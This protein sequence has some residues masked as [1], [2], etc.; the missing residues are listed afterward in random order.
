MKT[1]AYWAKRMEQLNEAQLAKGERYA[2]EMEAEY[3][4]ALARIKRDTEAW[5]A[6][7]AKNNDVSLAE[8]RK[9][10]SANE[11]QEFKWTV[12]DYIKAGRENAVDQ[13][14]MKQLENASAKVHISKLEALQTQIQQEV[15]L[16]AA[17][18][19]K[20]AADTLGGIYKDNY[21]K[22][23]FEL[24]KGTGDGKVM[25]KLDDAQI[26]KVLSKPWTP[27][28]RNFSS[29]IWA[30]RTKLIA[31]LQTTLT[32]SLINGSTSDKVIADFAARMGVSESNAK[33]LILT[34]AAYFAGQSR[35]DAYREME[36]ERYKYVATLD[37]RT[38]SVCR[39]MDGK[40]FLLSEAQPGVNYPPLHAHCRSTTIPYYE[41][42]APG[43][44][45]ARDEEG[46]T[47]HVP[48]DMTYKE[49]ADRYAPDA[50]KMPEVHSIE[51]KEPPKVRTTD[52]GSGR[53]GTGG[54]SGPYAPE[55]EKW[56][57]ETGKTAPKLLSPKDLPLD[58]LEP[59]KP[60]KLGDVDPDDNKAITK[61]LSDAEQVIRSMPDE[62]AIVVTAQ[63]EAY[64]VRGATAAV[65]PAVVG[66]KKLKG[67]TVTHNHPDYAGEP[68]GSFSDDD[69]MFFFT[70]ALAEL[71]AVDSEY[72]YSM[73]MSGDSRP[74]IEEI[75]ALILQ[76]EYR[77]ESLLTLEQAMSG[78]DLKHLTMLQLVMLIQGLVYERN[79]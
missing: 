47:H 42:A 20:G 60:R 16:L 59:E 5:Y 77:A 40:V 48:G 3:R 57:D 58:E 28:G 44:R 49:W 39:G 2:A 8:A 38:S 45:A 76:A 50:T 34:E 65:D 4:K 17:K 9:L 61:Y 35:L 63:G 71:R 75:A 33:R 27:D 25:P 26:D 56:Y 54:G 53:E 19:Q 68:G 21:Y 15:E 43:E 78:Y 14:W 13:R 67:A 24:Q 12:Q 1:E 41:D 36:V 66:K 10:L 72:R 74:S 52:L 46:K 79:E 29:R 31:E 32:Q 64:H 11:L 18:R 7:L 51:P 6:R 23:A 22:S 55:P 37:S 70:Y 73:R 30:D 62:H 69:V